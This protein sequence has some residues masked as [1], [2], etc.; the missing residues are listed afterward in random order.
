VLQGHGGV[1]KGTFTCRIG[2]QA[3]RGEL[4]GCNGKPVMVLFACAEDERE[5]VLQPRLIAAG[6][7]LKFIR[8]IVDVALP[9]DIT[10]GRLQE[11]I[12]E[13]AAGLLIIDPLVTHLDGV[14]T[15]KDQQIKKALTPILEVA[16]QERCTML[17]VHHFT[18]DTRRGA[19][20]SGNG[21]GAFG[22]TARL[23]LAMVRDDEDDDLRILEVVKSNGGPIG[24]ATLY[25]VQMTPIDG[26]TEHQVTLVDLGDS[27]K[28]ADQA[29]AAAG[30]DHVSTGKLQ[31]LVRDSLATGSKTREYLDQ[32]A[33]DE[34]GASPNQLYKR[35]L[36]PLRE[37][38]VVKA[39]KGGMD[40]GWRWEL[41]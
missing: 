18:K 6:A 21:S 16:A 20:L 41:A 33:K 19:L 8:Y 29:L 39:V 34:L 7:D 40:D 11:C 9:T 25:R 1:N 28:S 24:L 2:A 10:T 31:Q 13:V 5:T 14:D 38:G 27:K 37:S 15:W 17:G 26:L 22:N 23:V 12:R 36:T 32:V 30:V 4:E 3:S 35:A